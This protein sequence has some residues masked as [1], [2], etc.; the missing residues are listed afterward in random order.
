M[1]NFQI[2]DYQRLAKFKST[3]IFIFLL[4]RTVMFIHNLFD[5]SD[6][7]S[8]RLQQIREICFALLCELEIFSGRTHR[9]FLPI[10]LEQSRIFQSRQQRVQCPFHNNHLRFFQTL[11]DVARI[12]WLFG[13]DG[14]D[15]E[16]KNSLAH[17]LF[18]I[19]SN[20][21]YTKLCIN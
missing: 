6:Q 10:V 2:I 3:F 1:M 15:T 4:S 16:F 9:R 14:K 21:H 19:I 11:Y 8:P 13:D 7:F 20:V 5:R 18:R 17:L 12:R